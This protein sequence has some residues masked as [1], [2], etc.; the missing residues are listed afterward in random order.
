MLYKIYFFIYQSYVKILFSN[1]LISFLSEK[2]IHI[3]S[4]LAIFSR[5][6]VY[7]KMLVILIKIPRT[8]F[9]A[10]VNILLSW[11]NI[12]IP[13]TASWLHNCYLSAGQSTDHNTSAWCSL[14]LIYFD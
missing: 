11:E 4:Q 14:I 1:E 9:V 2:G 5:M 13:S 3:C 8:R 7:L 6:N 10:I 12:I